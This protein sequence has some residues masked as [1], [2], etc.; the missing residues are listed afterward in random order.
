M[1]LIIMI[2]VVNLLSNFMINLK[3]YQ[4]L[5]AFFF[6]SSRQVVSINKQMNL[7]MVKAFYEVRKKLFS[8][9]NERVR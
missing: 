5:L 3:N 7:T 8:E 4:A 6:N 9:R 2:F 1:E